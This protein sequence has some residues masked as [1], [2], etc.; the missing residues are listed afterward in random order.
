MLTLPSG[1][2][3]AMYARM[4]ALCE[5]GRHPA[6]IVFADLED[7]GEL[8]R[9]LPT[10]RFFELIRALSTRFDHTVAVNGGIV[11]KHA[12][13]GMTAFF[14][15]DLGY[16]PASAAYGALRTAQDVQQCARELS[17]AA[18]GAIDVRMNVALHWGAS[19]YFGQVVPGGPLDVTALGDEVTECAR[20]QESTHGGRISVSKAFVELLD[21]DD[22]AALEVDAVNVTYEPLGRVPGVGAKAVRDAA[23][24]AVAYL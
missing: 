20:M 21:A 6:A 18:G 9:R 1:D 17:H 7:S 8:S 15:T 11:G 2:E 23:T 19:L 3:D 4:R 12:G 13:D 14:L 22:A 24:L 16:G 5:P 10:A